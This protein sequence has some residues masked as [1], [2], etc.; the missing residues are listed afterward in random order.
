[1]EKNYY[2]I[3]VQV[4]VSEFE[5]AVEGMR[6]TQKNIQRDRYSNNPTR[7]GQIKTDSALKPGKKAPQSY[8]QRNDNDYHEVHTLLVDKTAIVFNDETGNVLARIRASV[9]DSDCTELDG[10]D[11]I[12]IV[13]PQNKHCDKKAMLKFIKSR[14][15]GAPIVLASKL[16]QVAGLSAGATGNVKITVQQ[17]ATK[18]AR[19]SW[20]NDGYTF[21]AH[22]GKANELTET[23]WVGKNKAKGNKRWVYLPLSHK[24]IL[25][26]NGETYD[27]TTLRDIIDNGD[28]AK[29]AGIEMENV[30]GLNKT[31]IKAITEDK[32]WVN[33]FDFIQERFDAVDWKQARNEATLKLTAGEFNER[34][35]K[36]TQKYESE[37]RELSKAK[38]IAGTVCK[39]WCVY[40]DTA[41]K[42]KK[43]GI[44]YD[45]VIIAM[46]RLFPN[47]D[48]G[49]S[50]AKLNVEKFEEKFAKMFEEFF[51]TYP[52]L[53]H[54][55][56]DASY[57][58]RD[59]QWDD[60]IQYIK[61][62]DN[63]S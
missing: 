33:F 9:D 21:E 44:Q 8:Y 53:K 50:S 16:P 55:S 60:A 31:S 49:K 26:P 63:A 14:L 27:A 51:A 23:A 2:G 15:P 36:P 40:W 32:R 38:T 41:K 56:L 17:F 24:T 62:V 52:M 54:V 39:A 28:I 20:R 58:Y 42:A 22:Y 35:F 61:L 59:D 45:R 46:T 4:P 34:D 10:Y 29:M 48:F 43:S 47:K 25:G 37:V 13:K 18:R 6:V 1:M 30:Y 3:N 11:N 5:K 57:S 7:L 12:L 19:S